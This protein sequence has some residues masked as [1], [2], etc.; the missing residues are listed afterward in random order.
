[1]PLWAEYFEQLFTVDP[2]CGQLQ[3][4]GLH[5]LDADP[6]I[7][8]T[9]PSTDDVND[10]V[11]KLEGGKAGSICN[12]SAKLHK[13]RCKTM[14]CRLH[15]VLTCAWHSGNIPPDW[16]KRCWSSPF[17]RGKG[18]VRTATTTAV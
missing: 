1:M 12:I 6:P 15:A 9:A 17:R 7:Y 16:K 11:A 18:I 2:T 8:K 4:A 3:T 10:A 5:T 14:I 13:A